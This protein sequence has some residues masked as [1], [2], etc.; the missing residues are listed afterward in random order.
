VD[1]RHLVGMYESWARQL[2]PTVPFPA[3][4]QQLER[5]SSNGKIQ[6]TQ[7]QIEQGYEDWAVDADVDGVSSR[8]LRSWACFL[9]RFAY[10]VHAGG[11][12]RINSAG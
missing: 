3:F 10:A 1:V 5:L 7:M 8:C 11:R 4:V 2:L 6:M 12:G 9:S